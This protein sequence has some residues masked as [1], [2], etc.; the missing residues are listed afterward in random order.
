MNCV[1]DFIET[2]VLYEIVTLYLV[3]DLSEVLCFVPDKIHFG[4]FNRYLPVHLCQVYC[5]VEASL[6]CVMSA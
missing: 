2:R 4:V 5:S 6:V 3:C 1:I